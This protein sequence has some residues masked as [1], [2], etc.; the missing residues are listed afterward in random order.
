MLYKE[1]PHIQCLAKSHGSWVKRLHHARSASVLLHK[2]L[3]SHA[4]CYILYINMDVRFRVRSKDIADDPGAPVLKFALTKCVGTTSGFR[5]A[6]LAM[7]ND[8][9]KR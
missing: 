9:A 6:R 4:L 8:E 3:I 1:Q 2:L 7:P 5:R